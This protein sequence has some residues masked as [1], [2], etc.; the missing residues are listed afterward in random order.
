M[1]YRRKYNPVSISMSNSY[2]GNLYDMKAQIHSVDDGS[3]GIWW[4][5]KSIEELKDCRK[6]L[7]EWINT[8]I[9][10]NG[11]EFLE[12]CVGLGADPDTKDYN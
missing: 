6:R 3:F 5:N 1:L 4:N 9:L 10:L 7:M 8:S 2:E 11:E 12:I